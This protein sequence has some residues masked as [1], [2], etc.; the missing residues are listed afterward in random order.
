MVPS[1]VIFALRK[2]W[3]EL[4]FF[5]GT[6]VPIQA[7][8]DYLEEGRPLNEF[9]GDFPTVSGQQATEVLEDFKSALLD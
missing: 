4:R 3:V 2:F 5:R 1:K 9:L 7:L 8:I 6:R